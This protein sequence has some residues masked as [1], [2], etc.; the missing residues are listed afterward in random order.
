[1]YNP[2]EQEMN[3]ELAEKFEAAVK[4]GIGQGQMELNRRRKQF[5]RRFGGTIAACILLFSCL[6]AIRVSPVFAAFIREIPGLEKFVHLI[7]STSDKGIKLAVDNDFV[8][9]VGVSDEHDGIKFTVQGIIAD[10]TRMIVFY[11]IQIPNEDES[12]QLERPSLSDAS[13][14]NLPASI[15]FSYPEEAKQDIRKTG[16]QRGIAD[17]QLAQGATLPDEVVLK[18]QFKRTALPNSSNPPKEM[19]AGQEYTPVSGTAVAGGTE[20]SLK[21]PIDRARFAGLQHEYAIGQTIRVEGQSVT[22]AKAVVSPLRISLYVDYAEDNTKQIFGPGDI[23][24][25]DDKGTVW[26]NNSGSMVQDHPVYHFESP[27]FNKPKSL[28]IEGSWFRALDKSLMSV[29]VDTEKGRLLQAPDEKLDLYAV[30][31]GDENTKLDFVLRGLD[32]EDKMM[33][34]LFDGFTDAAGNRYKMTYL[35]G[36]MSVYVD[37]S[38]PGEQHSMYYLEN[39]SYQQPLTLTLTDYPAYIRQ[40]YK[41]RIK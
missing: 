37:T 32:Q 33:Y 4:A 23:R 20:F 36:M 7:S 28:T 34:S 8:Q 21:I 24:L 6:L 29:T 12:F 19:I 26:R 41:I 13:G 25:V 31:K 22:F 17:F 16:I 10:D 15:S 5:R 3:A 27:Y 40:P 35:R 1:M 18:M 9:P 2:A 30:G 14:K 11:D 38:N 39:K